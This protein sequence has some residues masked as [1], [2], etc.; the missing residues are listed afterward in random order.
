MDRKLRSPIF[1]LCSAASKETNEAT[2][3]SRG[4]WDIGS[5]R[6]VIDRL[7]LLVVEEASR[8]EGFVENHCKV[9]G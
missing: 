1:L 7:A 5:V 8:T 4:H 2:G 3:L 6:I 9:M